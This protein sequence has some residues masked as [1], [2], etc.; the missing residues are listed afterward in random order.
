M[1]SKFL[2]L[3]LKSKVRTSFVVSAAPIS[4]SARKAYFFILICHLGKE[5]PA[6][7]TVFF[8]VFA[9]VLGIPPYL[10]L[11]IRPRTEQSSFLFGG[12]VGVAYIQCFR[13]IMFFSPILADGHQPSV[14]SDKIS[15]SWIVGQSDAFEESDQPIPRG[16][17]LENQADRRRAPL[18]G[19]SFLSKMTDGYPLAG[20]DLPSTR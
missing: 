19:K 7:S 6:I 2:P 15:I 9:W 10:F 14:S 5:S 4:D 8:P 18:H 11:Y 17:P 3:L 13:S 12:T 1:K 16:Y 20:S